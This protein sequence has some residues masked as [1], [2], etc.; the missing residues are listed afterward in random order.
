MRQTVPTTE[1]LTL[2]AAL[3]LAEQALSNHDSPRLDAEVL[4]AHILDKPRSHLHAWPEKTLDAEA[5]A[6]FLS[7]LNR[8]AEGTPVAHLT[9][10]RE[11]W[12]L[13]LNVTADTLIPRPETELLV[14]LALARIASDAAL[15]IADLGTGS[16][17]IALALA[18]ERPRC[19]IVAT[20]RSVAAL[21][22]AEANAAR[23]GLRNVSLK[24]GD[25]LQALDNEQFDLI[26]SNPPYVA[27]QDPHLSRGDVRFEPPTALT[28][29]P[30]GLDD[31]RHLIAN[32]RRW[33]R[34]N[35]W[36]L[37]EHGHD[38][39][40]AVLELLRKAGYKDREDYQDA[41]GQPRAA[42]GRWPG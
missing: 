25:W 30:D 2:R 15:A 24:N 38:Q 11:F 14:E 28:A 34:P 13:E 40:G 27:E 7:L 6:R 22:V 1:P 41:G 39:G 3:R 29:G 8:R 18:S 42:A 36:L 19:R 21:R 10:W 31:I 35:G 37:L 4:L 17:A 23:L 16:G 20:D 26:V 5:A 32:A 9:G 33:L 12:S